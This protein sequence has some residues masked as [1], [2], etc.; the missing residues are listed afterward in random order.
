M[1]LVDFLRFPDAMD[2]NLLNTLRTSALLGLRELAL[3]DSSRVMRIRQA[4]VFAP[5]LIL[6]RAESCTH[7]VFDALC[8]LL[9]ALTSIPAYIHLIQT[10]G[11]FEAVRDKPSLWL[12]GEKCV[13]FMVCGSI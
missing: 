11:F 7:G 12:Q 13:S 4:C 3:H 1:L 10:G 5:M 9:A 8:G 6:F 2:K